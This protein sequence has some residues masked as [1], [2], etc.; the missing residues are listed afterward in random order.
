MVIFG[1]VLLA[2]L[3]FVLGMV[4]MWYIVSKMPTSGDLIITKDDDGYYMTTQ[5]EKPIPDDVLLQK[6]VIFRVKDLTQR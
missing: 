2:I 4:C 5:L 3:G 6:T 1:L